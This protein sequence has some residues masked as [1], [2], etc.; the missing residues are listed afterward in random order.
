MPNQSG[1]SVQSHTFPLPPKGFDPLKASAQ[2]LQRYG[3]PRR[4]DAVTEAHASSKWVKAFS[5]YPQFTHIT[6]E[7]IIPSSRG[8]LITA[9]AG[10]F[11]NDCMA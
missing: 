5:Q 8:Q 4:P 7:F 10:N 11:G 6:P 2:D 3:F 1:G 9:L